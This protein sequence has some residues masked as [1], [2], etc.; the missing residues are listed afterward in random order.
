M[1]DTNENLFRELYYQLVY[2]NKERFAHLVTDENSLVSMSILAGYSI[3]FNYN[4]NPAPR[5]IN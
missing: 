3:S 2:K 5:K 4:V 1:F